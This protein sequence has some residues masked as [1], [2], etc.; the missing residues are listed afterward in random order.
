MNKNKSKIPRSI[1]L[2]NN[3]KNNQIKNLIL[4]KNEMILNNINNDLITKFINDQYEI[5]N[6]QYNY[7]IDKYYNSEQSKLLQT[8]LDKKMKKEID[9]LI[10]YNNL[11][12]K[13]NIDK[14]YINIIK[15]QYDD[16]NSQYKLYNI[17]FIN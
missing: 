2:A 9:I 11:L 8:N 7:K 13:Y 17:N 6:I 16:I 14:K 15:K 1:I 4:L 5:I 3:W 10:K 12:E